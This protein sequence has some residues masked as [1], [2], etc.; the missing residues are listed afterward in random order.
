M[1]LS[2]SFAPELTRG[3]NGVGRRLGVNLETI[4]VKAG[5]LLDTQEDPLL[6]DLGYRQRRRSFGKAELS[7]RGIAASPYDEREERSN[8]TYEAGYFGP[9]GAQSGGIICRSS[10]AR[11]SFPFSRPGTGRRPLKTLNLGALA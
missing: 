3:R 8:N 9:A 2:K 11:R 7:C 4:T 5:K 1:T 10:V 6:T